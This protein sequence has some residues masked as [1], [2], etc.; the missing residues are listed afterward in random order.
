LATAAPI[1]PLASSENNSALVFQHARAGAG[2]SWALVFNWCIHLCH[3]WI[4]RVVTLT[5]ALPGEADGLSVS[6]R[7]SAACGSPDGAS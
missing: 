5:K 2:C 1:E 6:M 4:G 7:L 3:C